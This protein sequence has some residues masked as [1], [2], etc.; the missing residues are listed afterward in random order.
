MGG[1]LGETPTSKEGETDRSERLYYVDWTRSMAVHMVVVLH[2]LITTDMIVGAS[3]SDPIFKQKKESYMR[4]QLQIGIPV[5]F[6]LS[7]ISASFFD[8]K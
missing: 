5:F 2:S 4:I 3:K 1:M 6:F 8:T 7:G